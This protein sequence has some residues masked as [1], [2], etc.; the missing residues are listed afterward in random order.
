MK[1]EFNEE[2]INYFQENLE[3]FKPSKDFLRRLKKAIIEKPTLSIIEN[4]II[5]N[6]NL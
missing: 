3:D 2:L 6:I 1:E 4:I 5:K